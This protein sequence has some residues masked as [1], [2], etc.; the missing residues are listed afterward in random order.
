[1]STLHGA[2]PDSK[3]IIVQLVLIGEFSVAVLAR[4]GFPKT[5]A[6]SVTAFINLSQPARFSLP[7]FIG[8]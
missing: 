1:M 5:C 7:I 6:A 4:P 8:G 2:T 3:V